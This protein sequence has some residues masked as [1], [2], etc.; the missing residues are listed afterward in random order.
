MSSLPAENPQEQQLLRSIESVIQEVFQD[1]NLRVS[2]TTRASD[3][4]GW[5]SLAHMMLI[6][7]I[8]KK[9]NI[10]FKL[11]HLQDIQ[12]VGDLVQMVKKLAPH[13]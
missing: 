11:S 7:A 4:E 6:L 12:Q 10:K 8:E 13:A 3:V 2:E 1:E 5:D 9:F